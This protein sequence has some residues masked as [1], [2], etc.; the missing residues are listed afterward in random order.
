[1]TALVLERVRVF[2]AVGTGL[3]VRVGV[4]LDVLEDVGVRVLVE[5]HVFDENASEP[6]MHGSATPEI[7]DEG[8]ILWP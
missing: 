3:L 8:T 2:V 4:K 6:E 5:L 1:M 7:D